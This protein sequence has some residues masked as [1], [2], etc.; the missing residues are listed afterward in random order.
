MW[1]KRTPFQADDGER[2]QVLVIFALGLV[3]FIALVGL[4][5]DVGMIVFTRTN[6]QK[7]ADAGALA[8]SQELP[9]TAQ[10]EAVGQEYVALNATG[11]T[12]E[13]S[14]ASSGTTNDTV[15][16]KATKKA[17]S[18]FLKVIG[19]DG[20]DVG[21]TATVRVNS[22]SGGSG[23]VPFGLVASNNNNSTLL[24]NPCFDG[25][26]GAGEPK[27][28]TG[29]SCTLQSGA[30]ENAGGDFGAVSLDA[31]GADPYRENIIHGSQ[32]TYKK[33][34][35]IGSETGAMAGP[36]KQ[37]IDDRMKQ[38]LPEGCATN[39]KSDVIEY[40]TRPDG[41]TAA[42]VRPECYGHPNIIMI[43][44][45]DKIDNPSMSTILGFAFM[46]VTSNGQKGGHA[47]LK[48]EFLEFV[49]E[50]PGGVY[51]G[52]DLSGTTLARLVD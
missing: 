29:M 8:A 9:S 1:Q 22:F 25:W 42:S 46:W 36:T 27:F 43:P 39:S 4:A 34:D 33:G 19:I 35:L 51:E 3:A 15:T 12:A 21:A 13:V 26:T 16:V 24:Q 44:V 7:T 14:F 50:I 48:G 49:T 41:S 2:G 32:G 20:W 52:S 18:I 6:L 28:K 31:S 45:V 30:G 47:E 10:A 5:V 23:L 38:P 17:D 40:T 37:G 11:A